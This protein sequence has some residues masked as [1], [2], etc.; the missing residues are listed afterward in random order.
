[1]Q[2]AVKVSK[3]KI[4]H[5]AALPENGS[6]S[7]ATVWFCSPSSLFHPR[8]RKQAQDKKV[9]RERAENGAPSCARLFPKSPAESRLQ[10]GA[11]TFLSHTPPQAEDDAMKNQSIPYDHIHPGLAL[12]A[13]SNRNPQLSRSMRTGVLPREARQRRK[14]IFFCAAAFSLMLGVGHSGPRGP[15]ARQR[16]LSRRQAGL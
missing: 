7:Q 1:M 8:S 10:A 4:R 15:A 14:R 12:P 6:V 11:R 9:G 3:P 2:G 16:Q 13:L 5:S